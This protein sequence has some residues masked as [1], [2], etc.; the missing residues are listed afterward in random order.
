MREQTNLKLHFNSYRSVVFSV[1]KQSLFTNAG[2]LIG[3]EAIN[4]LIGFFFWGLATQ[5]YAPAEIGLA[6]SIISAVA[7]VSLIS[8]LGTGN[9]LIR[10]LPESVQPN[11]MVNSLF[12]FNISSAILV[13]GVA[14]LSLALFSPSLSFLG[15]DVLLVIGFLAYGITATFAGSLRWTYLALRQASFAFWQAACTNGSRLVLLIVFTGFGV[16]GLVG[17]IWF[18]ITVSI[19]IGYFVFLPR[20]MPEFR[21]SF[22]FSGSDLHLI[23]PYSFGIYLAF[24]LIQAPTRLLP[25]IV[26]ELIGPASAAHAQIALLIGGMLVTPGLALAT[27]AFVEASNSPD[28]FLRIY[29]KAGLSG[30]LITVLSALFIFLVAKWFLLLFGPS[31][32]VEGTTLLRWLAAAAPLVV[33]VGIYFSLLRFQ[34]HVK[35]LVILSSIIA[36]S[37]LCSAVF[38]IPKIGIAAIGLGWFFGYLLVAIFAI[39]DVLV[40]NSISDIKMLIQRSRSHLFS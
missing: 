9:G 2:Y 27:S 36:I 6:S 23:L 30:L 22:T 24:L 29:S 39:R 8:G 28:S 20:A 12:I 26:L 5:L 40:G 14:L 11:R 4:A 21:P 13:G 17:S 10:F 33:L 31:Y 35:R 32:S 34:K 1:I 37:T 19:L 7:L 25:I 16:W 38:L 3:V 15:Q 18:A